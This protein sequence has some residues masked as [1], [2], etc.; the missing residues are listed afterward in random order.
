MCSATLTA[1]RRSNRRNHENPPGLRSVGFSCLFSTS[2]H[3]V[4]HFHRKDGGAG[5]ARNMQQRKVEA[6]GGRHF[7]PARLATMARSV[8][9]MATTCGSIGRNSISQTGSASA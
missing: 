7:A 9:W 2:R 8:S 6:G 5:H 1:K 3:E 4:H